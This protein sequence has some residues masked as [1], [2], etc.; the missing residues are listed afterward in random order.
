ME[1]R[2]IYNPAQKDYVTFLKTSAETGGKFTL[3]EVELAPK[4]GVGIHFHKTYS[5][6]FDCLEGELKVQAGKTVHTLRPGEMII[7][8]PFVNHRFFND[9]PSVT[10]FQVELRPASRGFE[11]SLQVGYGLAR[12]GETNS[13]GFPKSSLAL[14]WLFEISESNLPGWRSIFEFILRIQ[15]AKAKRTGLD[16][17]LI[18]K[19]VRF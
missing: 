4:G 9:S 1:P 5:E 18:E 2:R 7:A 15:A 12:D 19:Y 16:R 8:E 11:Q 6:K 17:K 10:K 3:V 13:K 14:A